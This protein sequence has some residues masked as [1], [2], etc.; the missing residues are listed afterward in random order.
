MAFSRV[1]SYEQV[2]TVGR[3][4]EETFELLRSGVAAFSNDAILDVID[5]SPPDRA[6][7]SVEVQ[8]RHF[9]RGV[10]A[11]PTDCPGATC[12]ARLHV[13]VA[14]CDQPGSSGRE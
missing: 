11:M 6:G 7:H 1:I 4:I 13:E 9:G 12:K 10:A 14:R 8:V 2:V 3:P 5:E